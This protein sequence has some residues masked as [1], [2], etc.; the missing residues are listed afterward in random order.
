MTE[1]NGLCLLNFYL[2]NFYYAN[3][4]IFINNIKTENI[5]QICSKHILR[6]APTCDPFFLF[7]YGFKI[8]LVS[9]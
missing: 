6:K 1:L 2:S 3:C 5:K 9:Q 8:F 7:P 4:Q